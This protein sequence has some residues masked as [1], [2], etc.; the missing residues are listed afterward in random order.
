MMVERVYILK[1][2]YTFKTPSL[3]HYNDY[4]SVQLL[5]ELLGNVRCNHM[6]DA[7]FS[8]ISKAYNM[9]NVLT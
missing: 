1:R 7:L 8:Y 2:L 6:Y 4:I 3:D 5:L 9:Y